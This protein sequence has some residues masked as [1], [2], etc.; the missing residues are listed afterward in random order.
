[1]HLYPFGFGEPVDVA[2][3]AIFLLSD[4][5]KFISGQNYVV[6]SGGVR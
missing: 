3:L 2:N 1:M 4:K 6:D 5:A